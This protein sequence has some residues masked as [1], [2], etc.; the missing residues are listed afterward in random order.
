[1]DHPEQLMVVPDPAGPA[2]PGPAEAGPAAEV[3]CAP[4]P[5]A[6][7]TTGGPG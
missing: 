5:W 7:R 3:D 6:G 1:M 2:E 4:D